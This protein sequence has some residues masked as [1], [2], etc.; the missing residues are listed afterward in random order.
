LGGQGGQN[1]AERE[2]L[3]YVDCTKLIYQRHPYSTVDKD[4]SIMVVNPSGESSQT[5][6]V[7]AP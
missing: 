2:K 7:S 3:I 5:I 1:L 6:N 4:F